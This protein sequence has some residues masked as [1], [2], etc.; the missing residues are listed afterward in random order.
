MRG[1]HLAGFAIAFCLTGAQAQDLEALTSEARTLSANLIQ[2][3]GGAL[4]KELAEKGPAGAA[5]V[6]KTLAPTIAGELSSKN[7]AKLARVSLKP[8]NP[9]LG[10]PDAWEQQQ[11]AA[12]DAK[13][14]AG[15]KP[16]TLEHAAIVEEPAGKY[17][18]YMK[19]LPVQQLCLTCHGDAQAI[20]AEV[21]AQLSKDYPADRAVGYSAGQVRGAITV[22]KPL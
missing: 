10:M 6:C 1:T 13:V 15:E 11:L 3:L 21:K 22:K 5:Q 4:K 18:R 20:P 8:R 14:Q 7:G 2:Q 19:A 17:F 12:F 9:M 16:E